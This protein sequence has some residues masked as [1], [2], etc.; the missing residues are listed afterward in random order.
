[1]ENINKLYGDEALY[2]T[3]KV[4]N[5]NENLCRFSMPCEKVIKKKIEFGLRLYDEAR[6]I[7]FNINWK[8]MYLDGTHFGGNSD[9]CYIP[10]FSNHR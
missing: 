4:C 10:V 1:V 9:E 6:S 3:K 7:F 8:Y 5:K 2:G